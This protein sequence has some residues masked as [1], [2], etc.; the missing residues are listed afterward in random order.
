M[1]QNLENLLKNIEYTIK[2]SV[3]NS[4]TTNGYSLYSTGPDLLNPEY[5]L[6]TK[7]SHTDNLD[8]WNEYE[9]YFHDTLVIKLILPMNTSVHDGFAQRILKLYKKCSTKVI[10][11]ERLAQKNNFLRSLSINSTIF[12]H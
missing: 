2:H 11:Q 4:I 12:T 5:I 7:Y 1:K 10:A 3:V 6:S 8:V 9:I